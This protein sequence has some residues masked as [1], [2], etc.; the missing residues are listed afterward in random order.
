MVI[1]R[2]TVLLF[3]AFLLCSCSSPAD[4]SPEGP[5]W[6]TQMRDS[7]RK[8]ASATVQGAEVVRGSV[9]TAYRGVKNGYAEPEHDAFGP[10]PRDYVTVIQKHMRRF[11]GVGDTASFE[12]GRP[13]RAYLNKGL[14]RGGEVDW[15]GWVVDLEIED[16]TLFGQPRAVDYVVRMKDGEVLEVIDEAHAGALT[17][18]S[19][20]SPPAPAAPRR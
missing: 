4:P 6:K 20:A 10:Y 19:E 16:K 5:T 7:S 15:L 3:A 14:L 17:R 11:E 1:V 2:T 12:F 8:V 18:V 9:G 13:V